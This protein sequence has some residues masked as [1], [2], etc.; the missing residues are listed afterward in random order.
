MVLLIG[1]TI[2]LLVV[3]DHGLEIGPEPI[4]TEMELSIEL[5]D[6]EDSTLLGL[7]ELGIQ[8]SLLAG[9]QKPLL[10]EPYL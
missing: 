5:M 10:L 3:Q 2:G 6:G 9:D 1:E 8:L 7:L 4:G